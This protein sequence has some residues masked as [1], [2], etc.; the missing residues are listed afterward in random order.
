MRDSQIKIKIYV[1]KY[2][3]YKFI[4]EYYSFKKK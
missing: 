1:F 3:L 4:I 2:K